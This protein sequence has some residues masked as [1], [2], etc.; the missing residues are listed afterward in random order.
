MIYFTSDLHFSHNNVIKYCDRPFSGYMEMNNVLI[1]NWN[2]LVRKDD[3]IY[4]LGDVTL[5]G[6][7]CVNELVPKLKGKKY[8]VRGNHDLFH[9]KEKLDQSLF[10]WIKDYYELHYKGTMF[11]LSH[12]PYLSW[13]N[14]MQGSIHLHGHIHAKEDY[15]IKNTIGGVYRFDVGVDANN[16]FPVSIEKIIEWAQIN[17]NGEVFD[18]HDIGRE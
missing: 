9:N 7:T 17:P 4:I 10:E 11:C 13:N 16:Y 18:H 15:N 8:L 1:A 5:K 6:I 2:S 12:Y 14:R 3:T